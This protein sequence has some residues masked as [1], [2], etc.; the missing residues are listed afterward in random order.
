[1]SP[2]VPP[3]T[4]TLTSLTAVDTRDERGRFGRARSRASQAAASRNKLRPVARRGE[5]RG[6]MLC[7]QRPRRPVP[8]SCTSPRL[9]GAS[10]YV[11]VRSCTACDYHAQTHAFAAAGLAAVAGTPIAHQGSDRAPCHQ[12]CCG[13][14]TAAAL[15]AA[16]EEAA[17]PQRSKLSARDLQSGPER[18]SAQ[19][20]LRKRTASH[21]TPSQR[22]SLR[23]RL[24]HFLGRAKRFPF[25]WFTG[26]ATR[27]YMEIWRHR[28]SVI[29]KLQPCG[30]T[31][32]H[33]IL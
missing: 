32:W 31:T 3:P 23:H 21:V 18:T 10:R 25:Q 13:R 2:R 27:L 19:S 1:M 5:P 30:E 26:G 24:A 28:T 7:T 12:L 9:R 14:A 22:A 15:A 8:S 4:Q 17:A 20:R 33:I 6:Q 29:H 16:P 11:P